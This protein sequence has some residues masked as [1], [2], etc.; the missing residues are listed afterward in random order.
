LVIAQSLKSEKQQK[1]KAFTYS[2]GFH[3]LYLHCIDDRSI[4]Y[5][6]LEVRR[7]NSDGEMQ[8]CKI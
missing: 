8:P 3:K 2:D 4:D 6:F 1:F 7:L 5:Q